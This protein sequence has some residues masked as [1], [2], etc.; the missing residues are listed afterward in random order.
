MSTLNFPH[1]RSIVDCLQYVFLSFT[2]TKMNS[3]TQISC[4]GDRNKICYENLC[5]LNSYG[6]C[7]CRLYLYAI[8]ATVVFMRVVLGLIGIL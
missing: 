2:I 8:E 5:V 4:V 6:Y 7:S 1:F 3:V